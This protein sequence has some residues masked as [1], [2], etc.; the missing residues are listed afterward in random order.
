MALS[1]KGKLII[2]D[3]D[4]V[5]NAMR[6]QPI[7]DPDQW[8]PLPGSMDAVAFLTQSGY[9]VVV[10]EN[11]SGIGRDQVSM[12]ELNEVH[13]K[14][15]THIQKAGGRLS[16]VWFCPHTNN[17][18]CNCRKP[19]PG[20]LLDILDRLHMKAEN[21]W[22]VGDG[23]RDMQAIAAIGGH[24]V[25]VLTGKGKETLKMETLPD[26]TQVYDDLLDFAKFCRTQA[27]KA[28]EE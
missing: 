20:L 8:L 1:G 13:G 3:R 5:L 25:L 15:H 2:L 24:P 28:A 17:A 18:K 11:M 6:P 14:M 4:G 23:I 16:G 26:D 7:S 19:Q 21:T 22:L 10:A 9:T 27:E 12:Q